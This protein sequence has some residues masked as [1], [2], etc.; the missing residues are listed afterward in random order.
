MK[1]LD[2]K[3][4][5]SLA[6]ILVATDFTPPAQTAL[7]YAAAI[8]RRYESKLFVAHVLLPE[9]SPP[10]PARTS[11]GQKQERFAE[12]QME[13]L[14]ASASLEGIPHQGLMGRGEIWDALGDMVR[15]HEID[16]V[17]T[18]TRGKKGVSKV[19]LG[20][21]AEEIFRMAPCPV[22]TVGPHASRR[23]PEEIVFRHILYPTDFGEASAHAAPYAVS[24]AQENQAGITLLHV[25]EER[26]GATLREK[27]D[28][29]TEAVRRLHALV[30]PEAELW[31]EPEFLVRMGDA[32]QW[33]LRVASDCA[34][35][36][37]VMGVKPVAAFS[38][39]LPASTAYTMACEAHC[40]VLTVRG[41]A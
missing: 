22:L 17:V 37:I 27:L 21:A 30:P 29:R 20:S 31:C 24:L 36:L 34:A 5:V 9:I 15:R 39:H 32:R 23:P 38:A 41:E 13:E 7:A 11:T 40:P 4:R 2:A 6:N 26:H 8:A 12:K 10:P 1:V 28:V 14:L 3:T 18:G 25:A 35:D 19:V 16:L 33:I